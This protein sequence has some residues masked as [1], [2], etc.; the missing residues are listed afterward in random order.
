MT[1][2]L[3]NQTE[4]IL[5]SIADGVFTVDSEWRITSFNRAAERITGIKKEEAIGRHCWNVFRASICESRCSLRQTM[6]TGEPIGNQA[7][8][9]VNSEGDRVP[10]SIS[11]ALLKEEE[12][13]VIGGAETFRDLSVVEELRKELEASHSFF[14]I[15]SKNQEMQ[16]LF[17]ILEQVAE[18]NSTVLLVGE[19]GTGK[20]LFAKAIHS[21]SPRK[22]GPMITVNC[23]ALP[24]TLLES[25]LFGYKAGAFTDAKKDKPGRLALAERGTLFLDEIGDISPALQ[26]RFLRFLQDRVYEPL[27]STKPRKA[28]VRIVAA[29]NKDLE[30]LVKKES[31]R[32][33]LY[34]RINVV[35][36]VL[37]ALRDRKEDIP[38]LGD[39]FVRKFNRLGG[40]EIQGF[41]PEVLPVL[42][43]H[44]F[45]GNIRELENIIEYATVVC[46][47]S[48]IGIEHLPDY[49]RP[50]KKADNLSWGSLE[51]GFLLETLKKNQW[52][53]SATAKELG[54]HTS[55][56]W[57]KMKR[58]N[59][60]AP[61]QGSPVRKQSS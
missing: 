12:G 10:V 28:D 22:S 34:Y 41:S 59:I 8:F 5:D 35:K 56:L 15:I 26:V 51:R 50:A 57:R 49:L 43:S 42:M 61:K 46:K 45:P 13:N 4:I 17:G 14:D 38:L 33:D 36:L 27:G 20:E 37:P 3:E 23:G 40:K 39:H 58:L 32:Q 11:T 24:D 2:P 25:E 52:S 48:L 21:M 54:I 9:I 7:I 6:E 44:D 1:Q 29:T 19:S 47:N 60:K 55:T 16:R 53:R 31:F 30:E 18:S